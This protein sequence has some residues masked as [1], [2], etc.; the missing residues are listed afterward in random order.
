MH[1]FVVACQLDGFL[2]HGKC[3]KLDNDTVLD[4]Q[5]SDDWHCPDCAANIFPHFN[6]DQIVT[7]VPQICHVCIKFISNTRHT[8]LMCESCNNYVHKSCSTSTMCKSCLTGSHQI[9]LSPLF[10]PYDIGE[11]D[12]DHNLYGDD[13]ELHIDTM[14]TA[15]NIL[16]NCNYI[17][18]ADFLSQFSDY[19]NKSYTSFYFQNIDGMKTNFDEFLIYFNSINH[20][21]DFV[22]FSE[23]N[24]TSDEINKFS[25]SNNYDYEVLSKKPDKM[26]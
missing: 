25:I 10:N 21:F 9:L 5:Q 12:D 24:L 2:Y 19:L 8:L 14:V 18:S 4:I 20:E 23:T 3:F 16:E 26:K 22:C 1:D 7:D 6:D 13:Y 15:S 17:D 11:S